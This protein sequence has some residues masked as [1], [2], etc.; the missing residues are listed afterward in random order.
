MAAVVV[1]V[2]AAAIKNTSDLMAIST[3]I[4]LLDL[5]Q[6]MLISYFKSNNCIL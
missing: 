4:P 2:A 5:G 6:N 1:V 3:V